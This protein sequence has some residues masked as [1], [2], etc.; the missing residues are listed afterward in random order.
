MVH[1]FTLVYALN[2]ELDS[3]DEILR[4]LA[5]NDCADAMV[6]W[7]RPGHVALAFSREALG[8]DAAVAACCG[9]DGTGAARGG[10]GPGGYRIV[11]VDARWRA[12]RTGRCRRS[13]TSGPGDVSASVDREA[14][15]RPSIQASTSSDPRPRSVASD[16]SA[17]ETRRA[18]PFRRWSF[19]PRARSGGAHVGG[20]CGGRGAVIPSGTAEARRTARSPRRYSAGRPSAYR[21]HSQRG[22]SGVPALA[23]QNARTPC[24]VSRWPAAVCGLQAQ[25]RSPARGEGFPDFARTPRLRNVMVVRGSWQVVSKG[26]SQ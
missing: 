21:P 10:T 4:R 2:P 17:G 13:L 20:S 15:L 6:G 7:G 16:G 9:S 18:A 8:H 3:Q 19:P 24:A 25:V 14:C 22:G 1:D 11:A 12:H 23:G 26:A 5:G